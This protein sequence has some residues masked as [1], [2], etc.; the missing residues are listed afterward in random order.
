MFA[1]QGFYDFSMLIVTFLW[2]L[3]FLVPLRIRL[4]FLG[5]RNERH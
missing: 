3:E 5:L 4:Q 1:R 2:Q